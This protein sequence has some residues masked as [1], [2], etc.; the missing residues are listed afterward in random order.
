MSEHIIVPSFVYLTTAV[1]L[2]D[3]QKEDIVIYLLVDRN[4]RRAFRTHITQ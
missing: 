2:T 1:D 3:P 4:V